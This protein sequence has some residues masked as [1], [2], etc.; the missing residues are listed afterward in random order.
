MKKALTIAAIVVLAATT[1]TVQIITMNNRCTDIA[2]RT[3]FEVA[4]VKPIYVC[5]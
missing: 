4:P 3:P 5:K 1:A 2:Q